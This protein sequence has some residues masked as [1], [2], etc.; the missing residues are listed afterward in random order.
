MAD[1]LQRILV[2][3]HEEVAA[4]RQRLPLARLIAHCADLAEPRGFVE[5]LRAKLAVGEPAVIAEIKK[6][7]PSKGVIRADFHPAEIARSYERGGAACLH[8]GS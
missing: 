3:K 8:P 5:A 7:S 6:A 1:I 4:R 2:R